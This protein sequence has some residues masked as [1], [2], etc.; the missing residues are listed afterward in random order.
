MSAFTWLVSK[1]HHKIYIISGWTLWC[2]HK[3]S[4]LLITLMTNLLSPQTMFVRN[5]DVI[6]GDQLPFLIT[7]C[8]KE[9]SH[10]MNAAVF[11]K[12][13]HFSITQWT[14]L[15]NHGS[16][17]QVQVPNAY[18]HGDCRVYPSYLNSVFNNYAP[19][20]CKWGLWFSVLAESYLGL[21]RRQPDNLSNWLFLLT[22]QTQ[23][24]NYHCHFLLLFSLLCSCLEELLIAGKGLEDSDYS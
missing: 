13:K 8:H 24:H 18:L 23:G 1:M 15:V 17:K 12:P 11:D 14:P 9:R 16:P 10:V 4:F 7:L 2:S 5:Q 21:S 6:T 20:Q 22:L 3:K 19:S